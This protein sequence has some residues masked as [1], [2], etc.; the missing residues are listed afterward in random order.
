MTFLARVQGILAV[1][2]LATPAL[3]D[4]ADPELPTLFDRLAAAENPAEAQ[5][6]EREIWVRWI[7][8][9][10]KEAEIMMLGGIDAMRQ[11]RLESAADAFTALIEY[12]P[13][14]AEAWNK[15]ATVLFYMGDYLASAADVQKTLELEPRHFGALSGLGMIFDALGEP[16]GALEAYEQALEVYPML[17]SAQVRVEQLRAELAGEAL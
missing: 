3:A 4:Q 14:Y 11:H 1:V 17:G 2:A 10:D 8:T 5:A 16:E 12:A 7:A 15:R 9:D 6:V 13:D